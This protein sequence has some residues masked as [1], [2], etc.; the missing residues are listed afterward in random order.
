M[1][2]GYIGQQAGFGSAGVMGHA[3]YYHQQQGYRQHMG[4]QAL[5]AQAAA[6]QA[7]SPRPYGAQAYNQHGRQGQQAYQAYN[8][9]QQVYDQQARQVQQA[10]GQMARQGQQA[11]QAYNAQA[12]AKPKTN[13]SGASWY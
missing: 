7:R 3:G 6:A 9:Q 12:A 10:Y 1:N 13:S 2:Y 8:Q 5:N 11:T 4:G